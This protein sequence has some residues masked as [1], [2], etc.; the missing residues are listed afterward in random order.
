M[1][2][3]ALDS[4]DLLLPHPL[5]SPASPITSILISTS[6]KHNIHKC[7][8]LRAYVQRVPVQQL[9]QEMASGGLAFDHRYVFRDYL[10]KF[11]PAV[12]VPV[13]L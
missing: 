8:Y 10:E 13:L 2:G 5:T 1:W 12:E 6:F 4:S 9:L 3:G 11:H 7:I